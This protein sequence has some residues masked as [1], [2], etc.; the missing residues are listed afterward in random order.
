VGVGSE[1]GVIGEIPAW[2]IWVV[3]QHDVVTVP[4]PIVGVVVVVRRDAPVKA[5]EPETVPTATFDTI[6]VVATNFAAEA[7][8][9]PRLI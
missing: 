7:S 4:Q 8:V 2:V 9:L 5:A 1:P 6:N 3:V